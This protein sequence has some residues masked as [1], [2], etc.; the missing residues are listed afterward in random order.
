MFE[1]VA[2]I[3][4]Q[5]CVL[6]FVT[7]WMSTCLVRSVFHVLVGKLSGRNCFHKFDVKIVSQTVPH[8]ECQASVGKLFFN[9]GCKRGPTILRCV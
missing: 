2:H 5:T 1:T 7:N 4:C 9:I 6:T 3:R 8:A